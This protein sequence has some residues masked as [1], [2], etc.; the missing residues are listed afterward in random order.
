MTF[1]YNLN[2]NFLRFFSQFN[3]AHF[4]F[5]RPIKDWQFFIRQ[6]LKSISQLVN[7]ALNRNQKTLAS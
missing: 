3:T 7:F 2:L 5:N 4:N 6:V 1:Y